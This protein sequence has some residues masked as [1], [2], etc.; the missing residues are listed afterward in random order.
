MKNGGWIMT[1]KQPHLPAAASAL[2]EEEPLPEKG[3]NYAT[4]SMPCSGYHQYPFPSL[5]LI[6]LPA[7]WQP[8]LIA[9]RAAP[10]QYPRSPPPDVIHQ[11]QRQAPQRQAHPSDPSPGTSR[12]L[13]I[14]STVGE[15]NKPTSSTLKRQDTTILSLARQQPSRARNPPRQYLLSRPHLSRPPVPSR[16]VPDSTHQD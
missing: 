16:I 11:S 2:Q 3:K 5:L 4:P 14:P 1:E 10:H 7:L 6:D 8:S 13:R 15:C 9:S 12:T